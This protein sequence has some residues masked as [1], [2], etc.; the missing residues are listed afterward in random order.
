MPIGLGT[1]VDREKSALRSM[2]RTIPPA[3]MV[4]TINQRGVVGVQQV[5]LDGAMAVFPVL[6]LSAR[7]VLTRSPAA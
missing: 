2:F 4:Q 3:G 1:A 7:Q 5:P 6:A